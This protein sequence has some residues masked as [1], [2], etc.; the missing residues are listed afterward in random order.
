[1]L[2]EI[3]KVAS[4]DQQYISKELQNELKGRET[5]NDT[6]CQEHLY[7][8]ASIIEDLEDLFGSENTLAELRVLDDLLNSSDCIYF[9]IIY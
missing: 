6:V 1:M 3:I 9:R 8:P 4:I 7:C 2:G 5:Y